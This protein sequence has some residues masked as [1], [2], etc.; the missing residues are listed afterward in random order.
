MNSITI[1]I[2]SSFLMS[3]VTSMDINYNRYKLKNYGLRIL[4]FKKKSGPKIL[5]ALKKFYDKCYEKSVASI[6]EGMNDYNNNFTEEEKLI[7]ETLI[8]LCY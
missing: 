5:N 2:I 6:A 8:S 1:I 3:V 7:I 4:V